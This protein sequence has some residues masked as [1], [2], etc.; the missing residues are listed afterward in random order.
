VP[1]AEGLLGHASEEAIPFG[2]DGADEFRTVV[3]LDSDLGGIKAVFAE[4]IQAKSYEL[5]RVEGGELIGVTD[6]SSGGQDVFDSIFEFGQDTTEHLRVDVRDIV[7]VLDVY[8]P[9][10]QRLEFLAI[11]SYLTFLLVFL[12]PGLD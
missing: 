12:L 3:G 10:S 7:E 2:E 9:M 6:E 1:S 8:L 5:G 11:A 4:V